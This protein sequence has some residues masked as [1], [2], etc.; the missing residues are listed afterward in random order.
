MPVD[1]LAPRE[2]V[3]SAEEER[4]RLTERGWTRSLGRSLGE[5]TAEGG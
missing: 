4:K 5:S 2:S 3:W 1:S